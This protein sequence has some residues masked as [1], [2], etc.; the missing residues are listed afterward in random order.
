MERICSYE[1]GVEYMV[2]ILAGI[3]E[4]AEKV[5]ETSES[6][7]KASEALSDL[8][9][10]LNFDGLSEH[11]IDI[12]DLETEFLDYL[13]KPLNGEGKDLEAIDN[14]SV[15]TDNSGVGEILHSTEDSLNDSGLAE[16]RD[17]L[18]GF[19]ADFGD[20]FEEHINKEF[21]RTDDNAD[22][23]KENDNYAES[24]NKDF[25]RT[26]INSFEDDL[27]LDEVIDE[28]LEEYDE[29]GFRDLTE[30]EKQDLI[31]NTG[32]P[33]KTEGIQGCKINREGVIK[34]PCRNENLAGKV[35]PITGIE[36][37][38]KI[39]E[40]N[41]YKVEVVAPKFE[42]IFDV[43]LPDDLCQAKDKEQFKECNKQLY[44]KIQKNPEFAKQFTA[45]QI[46]QIKDGVTSGGAPDGFVWH[47]DVEKG[48]MQLVDSDIH[49]DTRHTGGKTLWGGGNQNR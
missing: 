40:I 46:E 18:D 23:I 45:E 29:N 14:Q 7:S 2:N 12:V 38:K 28:E 1:K 10:P 15:F 25:D 4:V 49:F 22:W 39:V 6:L 35:N 41:G 24:I 32:W 17:G 27:N 47:H 30:S 13:D 33:D 9:K 36:Y 11:D 3:A 44:D 19:K 5:A 48:K 8:D 34:Y 20:E 31:S 21:N 42:S 37:E 16:N 26:A 43:E